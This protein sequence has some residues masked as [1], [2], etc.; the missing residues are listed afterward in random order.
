VSRNAC[1]AAL[2]QVKDAIADHGVSR[3]G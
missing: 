2:V 3:M 1:I